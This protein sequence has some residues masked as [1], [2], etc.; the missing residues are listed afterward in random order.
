MNRWSCSMLLVRTLCARRL[1]QGRWTGWTY[2]IVEPFS[3]ENCCEERAGIIYASWA[4]AAKWSHFLNTVLVVHGAQVLE[5]SIDKTHKTKMYQQPE[6]EKR[7]GLTGSPN[8]WYAF[9]ISLNFS[10]ASGEWFLSGWYLIACFLYAF[11]NSAS[12]ASGWTPSYGKG[13]EYQ[14]LFCLSKNESHEI[15]ISCVYRWHSIPCL[16][17]RKAGE[18]G[19]Q[20]LRSVATC[21][22]RQPLI[23]RQKRLNYNVGFITSAVYPN[24]MSI[25]QFESWTRPHSPLGPFK[26][27]WD[28]TRMH[29]DCV[30]ARQAE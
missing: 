11:F 21:V 9:A 12:L 3:S 30:F 19:D 14:R 6:S 16:F 25:P 24:S 22:L 5:N 23:I 8:T 28:S 29:D 26:W 27:V 13:I 10:S 20:G 7:F 4:T 1:V 15:I 2:I 18:R 17:E